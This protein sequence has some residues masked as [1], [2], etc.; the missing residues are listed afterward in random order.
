MMQHKNV[1]KLIQGSVGYR[2]M[3]SWRERAALATMLEENEKLVWT[4]VLG[5]RTRFFKKFQSCNVLT[6]PHPYRAILTQPMYI[7]GHTI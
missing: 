5:G 3:S 1:R 6:H 2:Q 7:S 4:A